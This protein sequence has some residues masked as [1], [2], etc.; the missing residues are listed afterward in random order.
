M[1]RVYG[2]RFIEQHRRNFNSKTSTVT[3]IVFAKSDMAAMSLRIVTVLI[4]ALLQNGRIYLVIT[5]V[6]CEAVILASTFI[7]KAS[8]PWST[9][10]MSQSTKYSLYC[11]NKA[12]IISKK[13]I[14]RRVF[15]TVFNN[16]ELLLTRAY[17]N[18]NF[19]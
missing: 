11:S 8:L 13:V 2:N 10:S 6:F 17:F 19:A 9:A 1:S 7:A 16:L 5:N 18:F 3:K 12:T 15:E 14:G 4:S